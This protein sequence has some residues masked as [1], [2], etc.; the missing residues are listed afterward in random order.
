MDDRKPIYEW[1]ACSDTTSLMMGPP[2]YPD[3]PIPT[4]EKFLEDYREH[5]FDGYYPL[6][7]RCYVI[8][9]DE[10]PVGQVNHDRISRVDHSTQLD[11][12]LKSRKHLN[13]GYGTAALET[14]CSYLHKTYDCRKFIISPSARN[15]AAIRAY[16]KAGFVPTDEIPEGFIPDYVDNVIMV[17]H[18]PV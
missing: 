6:Q 7:G 17:K 12:W 10:E 3:S 2:D 15:A 14:L 1:L 18:I 8:E 5:F 4:W 13:K 16:E 11:I 9:V